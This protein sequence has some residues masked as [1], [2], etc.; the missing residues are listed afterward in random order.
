MTMLDKFS[1]HI[2]CKKIVN[3]GG[4]DFE[5]KALP[6]SFMPDFFKLMQKIGNVQDD[7][8]ME[9]F[10][11]ET[12]KLIQSLCEETMAISYPK[13]WK[14]NNQILKDFI[15]NNFL[16]LFKEILELNVPTMQDA[17]GKDKP[18]QG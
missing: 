10:D 7:K 13:E 8:V 16:E 2:K 17:K 11:E 3:L 1:R 5:L 14:E 18:A 4:D 12:V 6:Y 9:S 15:K